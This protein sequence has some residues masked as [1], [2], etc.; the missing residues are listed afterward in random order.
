MLYILKIV[1]EQQYKIFT[2]RR[3]EMPNRNTIFFL[4]KYVLKCTE[5]VAIVT[6]TQM[7]FIFI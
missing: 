4:N 5:Y 6:T 1:K 2:E 3:N 7:L